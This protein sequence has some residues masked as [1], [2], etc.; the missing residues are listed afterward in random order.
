MNWTSAL[1][2]HDRKN[3]ER[4]QEKNL[5]SE[6]TSSNNAGSADQAE[7]DTPTKEPQ[8]EKGK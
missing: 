6:A 2:A 1:A 8:L 7:P 5:E 3:R 4:K